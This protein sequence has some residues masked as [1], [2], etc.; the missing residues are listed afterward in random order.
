MQKT[1]NYELNKIEENDF[2][3]IETF[4]QNV[5]IIDSKFKSLSDEIANG[6]GS[7]ST[8]LEVIGTLEVGETTLVIEDERIKADKIVDVYTNV[9]GIN[10]ESVNVEDGKVTLTFEEQ[11]EPVTVKVI[12]R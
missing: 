11:T 3:D 4:N 2:F 8:T 12:L 7:S 9:Y 1:A 6:S 10:L 5:D